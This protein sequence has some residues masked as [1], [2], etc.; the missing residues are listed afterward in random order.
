MLRPYQPDDLDAVMDIA[1]RAWKPI[2][3]MYRDTY[4]PELMEILRPDADTF[5]GKQ[6]EAYC[7]AHP[8]RALVYEDAG[9][10]VAFVTFILDEDTRIGE[11]YA[12]AVDP[13]CPL[14]GLGQQMYQAVFEVFGRHNM[15]YAKVF[16]GLDD[17]HARARKAYER[18][19]FDIR[20]D[21][22][23]YYKEL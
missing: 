16:T 20:H 21:D 3:D 22:T 14:K 6:V 8:D 11:I 23:I 10:I 12:N 1:N 7:R 18:A 5:K 19:G 13:D 4:G 17:A 2:H 15:R 9:K